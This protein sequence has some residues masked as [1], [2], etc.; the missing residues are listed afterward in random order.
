MPNFG[1]DDYPK[2]AMAIRCNHH[3]EEER[4]IAMVRAFICGLSINHDDAG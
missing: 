3:S 2:L 4:F 1:P